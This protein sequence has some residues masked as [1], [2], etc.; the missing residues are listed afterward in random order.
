MIIPKTFLA[1]VAASAVVFTS[2]AQAAYD[3]PI[4][5]GPNGRY[6]TTADG[7][8]FLWIG[9]T[10][11][12]L[13]VQYTRDQAI[14]YLDA[15]SR[16]GYSVIQAVGVW[17]AG[18]GFESERP[19]ANVAGEH[20]WIDN[21]PTK[22]N[23]AYFKHLDDL[24]AQANQRNLV[25]SLM[26]VWGYYVV[27]AKTVNLQNARAFG[28]WIGARYKNTPNVI[29]DNGG[30]RIPMQFAPV[31][32]ELALG[33]REGDG[34]KHLI[35][36]HPSGWR[37]S[38][39]YFHQESWLDFNSVQTWGAWYHVHDAAVSDGLMTPAKPV[40]I[41]EGSYEE[42][43]EYPVGPITPLIVRRQAW[44]ALTGGAFFTNGH[45]QNWRMEAGWEKSFEAPGQMQVGLIRQILKDVAWWD[46]VPDQGI[47]L[48]GISSEQT[49][50]TALR[51]KTGDKALVYLASS[52][53]VLINF[54]KFQV[55]K[56]QATW[57]NPATNERQPAGEYLTG[58][59]NGK[60]WPD[61]ASAYFATPKNWE[62]ALLWIEPVK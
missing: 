53:H 29:F 37:S 8:P 4:R 35:S 46:M 47:I 9:D 16:Q 48:S 39:E 6:F 21:D 31:Y 19:M 49:L 28:R 60:T 54:E 26:V 17:G 22:P 7:K 32:R 14:A 1:L 30:D 51:A 52:C 15:K 18:S 5:V 3:A 57:I 44:W 59:D 45:T 55:R 43:P 11:W 38:A 23:D 41:A 13:F 33:L 27:D 42:G 50:N 20:P 10:A 62:D 25:V 36:Y 61:R 2:L 12:P 40:V 58:N 56:V 24:I 34:G